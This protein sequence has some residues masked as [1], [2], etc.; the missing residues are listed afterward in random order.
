MAEVRAGDVVLVRRIPAEP[1]GAMITALD[2]ADYSHAGI[3]VGGGMVASSHQALTE[4]R[5]P[6]LGGVRIEPLSTASRWPT[7]AAG[8]LS[9]FDPDASSVDPPRVPVDTLVAQVRHLA[10]S[11][12]RDATAG[13]D[14]P[15]R[16]E[17][18]DDDLLE[19]GEPGDPMIPPAL[20]TPR[21]LWRGV[22]DRGPAGDS[23]GGEGCWSR[24]RL[25][26]GPPKTAGVS[27]DP[28]ETVISS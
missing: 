16:R 4:A 1:R 8:A 21:M 3:A 6:D 18:V 20:V 9:A 25:V 12:L 22:V 27:T 14:V 11:V 28:S 13:E 7:P 23:S 2:G 10:E 19:A 15:A 26:A 5:R 24:Q 17:I